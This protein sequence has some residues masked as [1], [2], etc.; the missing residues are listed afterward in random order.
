MDK[1]LDRFAATRKKA[2]AAISIAS[3]LIAVVVIIGT[4]LRLRMEGFHLVFPIMWVGSALSILPLILINKIS[5]QAKSFSLW[6]SWTLMSFG[7][8]LMFGIGSAGMIFFLVASTFAALNFPFRRVVVLIAIKTA[9][10]LA[11]IFYFSMFKSLPVP[12]QGIAFFQQPHIW[13]VHTF[14]ISI[15][16]VAIVY[17]TTVWSQLNQ[18]L[19]QETEK[20]FYNGIGLLSLAH[21]TET[22]SHLA[23]VSAYC[24]IIATEYKKRHPEKSGGLNVEDLAVGAQLHDIGKISI[25]A[26]VL[27]KPGKLD[28]T[29]IAL[30]KMH[31]TA[32]A[33]LIS[34]II[35]KSPGLPTRRLRIAKEIALSHHENWNGSGYPNGLSGYSIPLSGRLVT[36]C[37]V[38]D[39]L[40][41]KRPYKPA[42][43][44][45]QAIEI[46][47]QETHKFDP[48]VFAIF[49]EENLKFAEVFEDISD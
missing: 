36:V 34:Q 31:T 30:I 42:F 44:H 47:K 13:V 4:L 2:N 12:P 32:G 14:L 15:A 41:S 22:G 33:E 7:A 18:Y 11:G 38:Y 49:E 28:P 48:D 20:S 23:R 19:A 1:Q 17:V 24:E 6:L 27:Q 9:I 43:S 46:M 8:F 39:A 3:A 40:R 10:L 16:A 29:E 45:A 25:P 26:S 37:D 35:D 21:D 5:Y